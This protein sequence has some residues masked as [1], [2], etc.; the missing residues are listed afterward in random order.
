MT[1]LSAEQISEYWRR[2]YLRVPRLFDDAEVAALKAEC[3]RLAC[4]G[5]AHSPRQRESFPRED[6]AGRPVRNLFDPVV[7]HSPVIRKMLEKESLVSTLCS[8]FADEACLFKD[9]LI[10]R[11]PGTA[12]YGLHQDFAYWGWTGVP[13]D[14]LLALQIAVDD[15]DERNGAVCFYPELHGCL[16]PA[17]AREGNDIQAELVREYRSELVPTRAGDAVLFHSLTPHWSDTNRSDGPRRTL[18]LTYNAASSGD[19]YR[20]YYQDRGAVL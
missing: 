11:P 18:Y 16:L 1:G 20:I 17:T 4:E 13:P 14:R 7:A 12:G 19:L 2:G 10:L 5:D 6:R 15:A 9:K 8:V 3:A